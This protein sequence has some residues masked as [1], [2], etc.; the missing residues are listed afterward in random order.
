MKFAPQATL[1][2]LK[3]IGLSSVSIL[4]LLLAPLTLFSADREWLAAGGGDFGTP[5]H[6]S[7][8]AVPGATDTAIF[9]LD[10][11][12]TVTIDGD[13]TNEFAQI[14]NGNV[15]LTLSP[16]RTYTVSDTFTVGSVASQSPALTISGGLDSSFDV[17]AWTV[18]SGAT[19][20]PVTTT[21]TGANTLVNISGA[22][23][24][25]PRVGGNLFVTRIENGATVNATGDTFR[26]E[27]NS[28]LTVSGSGSKLEYTGAVAGFETQNGNSVYRVEDGG[29]ISTQQLRIASRSSNSTAIVTGAGSEWVNTRVHMG[30][31]PN[32][33]KRATVMV[34]DGGL[35]TTNG[36]VWTHTDHTGDQHR[37]VVSGAGSHWS[38]TDFYVAGRGGTNARADTSLAVVDG[39][40]VSATTMRIYPK[41]T[42][43]GNGGITI[44]GA[45]GV[46]NFGGT[47]TPGVYAFTHSWN[48][49][50]GGTDTF[51]YSAAIG[52]LTVTGNYRQ[53]NAVID[54]VTHVPTLAIR[55]AGVG[56]ADQLHVLGDVDLAGILE[57]NPFGSPVLAA[58][59][60]FTILNWSGDL[61][62]TFNTIDAFDPGAGLSWNFDNLYIDG[63]ISVIPEPAAVG[64]LIAAMA[65]LAVCRRRS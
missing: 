58:N 62:G 35:M 39:G 4:A 44:T 32:N 65:A 22:F 38:A 8:N 12:Y 59:D 40:T 5:A 13:Y 41:G 49:D 14:A 52:T 2:A 6:W 17:A 60:T 9:N 51:S 64:L 7:G 30:E 11:T 43:S 21:I 3:R 50:A 61:T 20:Q 46:D 42:V 37:L 24:S 15:S 53:V 19:A 36:A 10:E 26:L 48:N 33:N 47:V 27:Y 23:L 1:A 16:D 57:I 54:S 29:Y 28:N 31:R 18:G 45:L 34:L 25:D 56:G 63:T 55:I